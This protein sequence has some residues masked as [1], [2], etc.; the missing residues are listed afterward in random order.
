MDDYIILEDQI[1][2]KFVDDKIDKTQDNGAE[3]G[4]LRPRE[5]EM[6]DVDI[7][8]SHCLPCSV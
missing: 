6:R 7:C 2:K 3:S 8:I 4:G 1:A 5:L